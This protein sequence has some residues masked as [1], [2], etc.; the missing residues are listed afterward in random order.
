MKATN[1]SGATQYSL[2]W[3]KFLIKFFLPFMAIVMLIMAICSLFMFFACG[4]YETFNIADMFNLWIADLEGG[5][6]KFLIPVIQLVDTLLKSLFKLTGGLAPAMH[7]R[8]LTVCYLSV[9][10]MVLALMA[11]NALT[12]FEK[13][14]LVLI[15]SFFMALGGYVIVF[16]WLFQ[17]VLTNFIGIKSTEFT[18]VKFF[19]IRIFA[20][21]KAYYQLFT[22]QFFKDNLF[23]GKLFDGKLI[24][25]V[26]F[27]E[28]R[29]IF[30]DITFLQKWLSNG[31]VVVAI[32]TVASVLAISGIFA[33]ICTLYYKKRKSMFEF[34]I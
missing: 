27:P 20:Y 33:L 32:V 9:G 7:I 8:H 10:V 1:T 34:S 28:G 17:Y 23:T 4:L 19:G 15:N 5:F 21:V 30:A 3:H 14:S 22:S 2:G 24:P 26:H 16:G 13:K 6:G 31:E 12:Y 18:R 29:D 25:S 11:K